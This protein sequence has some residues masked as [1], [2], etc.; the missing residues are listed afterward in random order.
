MKK[1]NISNKHK[2]YIAL[3]ALALMIAYGLTFWVIDIHEEKDEA[4]AETQYFKKQLAHRDSVYNDVVDLM[5]QVESQIEEIKTREQLVSTLGS[6]ESN[7]A[8]VDIVADLRLIDSLIINTGDYVAQLTSKL[9]KTEMNLTSFKKRVARLTQD[10]D[11]RKKTVAS[12]KE[13]IQFKDQKIA[14]YQYDIQN[15][16]A[17]HET[18][19]EMISE[20]INTIVEIENKANTGFVAIDSEKNLEKQNIISKDGG[21]LGIGKSLELKSNAS[22]ENFREID[23]RLVNRLELDAKEIDIV[24]SHPADSY[25]LILD[26]EKVKFLEITDPEEFWKLS[27]YL[28]IE[29]KT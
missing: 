6:S 12:L 27:K 20:N 23:I 16:E 19:M 29:T 7:Q 4:I 21:I 3:G 10:L 11:D 14:E 13:T 5:F 2:V 15:M 28:V 24:T 1:I 8:S 22:K 26:D 17:V 9:S 25:T 18:Q